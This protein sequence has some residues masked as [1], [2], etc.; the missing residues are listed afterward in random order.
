MNDKSAREWGKYF[1][2]SPDVFKT[3]EMANFGTPPKIGIGDTVKLSTDTHNQEY[4]VLS[5]RIDNLDGYTR[6]KE[7]IKLT[8]ELE[9][10]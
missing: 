7:P 3:Q 10:A 2:C 5:V 1:G 9:A 4:E 8:L 6:Y